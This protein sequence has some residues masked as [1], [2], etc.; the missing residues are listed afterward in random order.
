M[1]DA[2][3]DLE[4]KTQTVIEHCTSGDCTDAAHGHGATV[5]DINERRK[6]ASD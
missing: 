6:L 2:T 3:L 4:E 5:I 1:L